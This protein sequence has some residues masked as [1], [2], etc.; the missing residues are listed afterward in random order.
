MKSVDSGASGLHLKENLLTLQIRKDALKHQC[1]SVLSIVICAS[2][3]SL[4]PAEDLEKVFSG[5]EGEN[6]MFSL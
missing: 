5:A 1:A 3:Y 4:G 6:S 2:H